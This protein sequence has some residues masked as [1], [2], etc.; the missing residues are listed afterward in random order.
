MV[1]DLPWSGEVPKPQATNRARR[2]IAVVVL[3]VVILVGGGVT[4]LV[5]S[6]PPPVPA[7]SPTAQRLL[8]S[9]LAATL[10]GGSFHYVS[11]FTSRG[12][13][14][15]TVGDAGRS[16]GK[17]VITIGPDTFTVL[18]IGT[19]CYFQGDERQMVE[20]LG[21]PVAVA[22]ADAGQWISLAPGDVPYQ[23]VYVAVTTRSALNSNIAFEP[24]RQLTT[25]RR[26]GYRV[27]GIRG[28]MVNVTAN[29]QTQRAKGTASLYITASRPHLPVQYTEQG[30]IDNQASSLVMTFSKWGEPVNVS[31]PTG[32]IAYSSLNAGSGTTPT[33]AG[34]PVLT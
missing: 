7:I 14:Q 32:A 25:S 26:S 29:G 27:L 10:N 6:G 9:S 17:Q 28:P 4:L 33:T 19:A 15:T 16:S 31:A 12:S 20:Q 11:R 8:R 23:S 5:T 2:F 1:G 24:H 30:K 34:P 3:V 18:V 22:S 21:L 13:T